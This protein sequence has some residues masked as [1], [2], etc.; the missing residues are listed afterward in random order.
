MKN[1]L[2]FLFTFCWISGLQSQNAG[3]S[4]TWNGTAYVVKMEVVTGANPLLLGSSQVSIVTP[5]AIAT[6]GI[7]VTCVAPC[8]NG[9][10]SANTFVNAPAAAPGNNFIA[11][12][13]PGGNMGNVLNGSSVTL[14][15]FTLP[16]GCNEDV[17]L[18][19]N[20]TDPGSGQMPGGQDFGNSL[21]NGLTAGEFYNGVN[22]DDVTCLPLPLDLLR[23][24]AVYTDQKVQLNWLT[25]SEKDML[26]F[27]IQRSADGVLYETIGRQTAANTPEAL[28][29]WPDEHLPPGIQK[30]YYRLQLTG[31]NNHISYSPARTVQVPLAQFGVSASPVPASST[32][33]V[34]IQ[35][36]DEITASIVITDALQRSLYSQR[37]TLSKGENMVDISVN[38][39]P[40]GT[41]LLSVTSADRK[42]G[43]RVVVQH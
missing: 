36:P 16:G 20:G 33:T 38:N 4:L 34:H 24:A 37:H 25:Q 1:I 19:N 13:S 30:L 6:A 17:R 28:Y 42:T 26:Y 29:S 5:A 22:I 32:L 12:A 9:A 2:L 40:A 8:S 31:L 21:V 41:Y 35:S 11:I 14:F 10:W 3:L 18:F 27:D 7:S 23:F 39:W 43:I 15:T